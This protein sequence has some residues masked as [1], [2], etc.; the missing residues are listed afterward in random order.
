MD[1][2]NRADIHARAVLHADAGLRDHIRH[3]LL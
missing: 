2:I 1:A 3:R